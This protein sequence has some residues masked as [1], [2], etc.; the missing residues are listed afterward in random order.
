[1][2]TEP[3]Q[4]NDPR[5]PSEPFNISCPGRPQ[6]IYW[7]LMLPRLLSLHW[8]SFVVHLNGYGFS[9]VCGAAAALAIS[10]RRGREA[11][12]P[13]RPLVRVFLI[14][15]AGL[16]A[17]AKLAYLLQ[18]GWRTFPGG[19][20]FYGGLI[21]GTAA[22]LAAC[23][24]AGLPALEVADLGVP[25]ALL[26][27]AFGRLGCFFAGCCFGTVWD[28][29]VTY[30]AR[31]HAWTHHVRAGLIPA[32]SGRS[33]PTVP[34][35]LLEALA[36]LLIFAAA[37]F[38]WRKRP[39]PGSTLAACGLLYATWR[40]AAEFWRGDHDPYWG[41]T[42]TFSQG[43]SL[44]VL[45]LSFA[46]LR[47][48]AA[49]PAEHVRA[50]PPQPVAAQ[51]SILLLGVAVATGGVGCSKQEREDAAE[52]VVESCISS[53]ISSC[54]DACCESCEGESDRRENGP[55]TAGAPDSGSPWRRLPPIEP[56]RR[57][58]AKLDLNA[59]LNEMDARLQ[60]AG[61]FTVSTRDAAGA[62]LVSVQVSSL[63]LQLGN[64]S[65]S[66]APGDAE[67]H[68]DAKG[69]AVLRPTGLSAEVASV[70]KAFEPF[71]SG[72]LRVE[73]AAE[74]AREWA[75]RVQQLLEI[76]DGRGE[77]RGELR[78][79]EDAHPFAATA[80]ITQSPNGERRVQWIPRR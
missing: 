57:Y 54:T 71:G 16:F 9:I 19:W 7:T 66:G 12:L 30:P 39:R 62:Q 59:T 34:A 52:E 50:C 1:M 68:V 13:L 2:Q 20:V 24:R 38:W 35:P 28:G 17:G 51:V 73:S 27:A 8:G 25:C 69:R 15:V 29:G 11:A 63:D 56:A 49:R 42:L 18:Y 21:G 43:V 47:R 76:R 75:D 55:R 5:T 6:P 64:L 53:C 78:L 77:C 4:S 80:L 14:A 10:L 48:R 37:S 70:L 32:D 44:A 31:S 65:L 46:L 36:L 26:A 23:R 45:I 67:I 40:F 3:P 33:L 61:S 22:A 74:P 72:F 41:S 58:L 79:D 60:L